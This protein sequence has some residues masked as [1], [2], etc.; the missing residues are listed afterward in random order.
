ME[1]YLKP[2]DD[3]LTMGE[4]GP[5]TSIKLDY[6]ARYIDIF[7]TAMREKW[8]DRNYIDL[9]SGA[10][11]NRIKRSN[12]ILLGSPLLAITTTY[13]FTGYLFVDNS[14]EK[15]KALEQRCSAYPFPERIKIYTGDCNKVVER[16]VDLLKPNQNHS[17]NL[18]FL[19]PQGFELEWST[20]AKLASIKRM[21]LIIYYPQMGFSRYLNEAYLTRGSNAVDKFFGGDEWR[22]IYEEV[23]RKGKKGLDRRLIDLYKSKLNILG[24]T[25]VFRGNEGVGEE[26]L[27]RNQL[28][29]TP[30]YRLLFA[31]KNQLGHEFWRK[32]IRRDVHG[33]IQLFN[34]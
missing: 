10:G 32:I 13:P 25:E 27:I 20:L 12:K 24:Y 22:K 4:Y 14:L 8:K 6:L 5:W 30:L 18:A 19:D 17:L 34:T 29:N 26:P 15:T 21:D 3:G 16:V 1:K 9:F 33:Q 2:I 7:E 28:R 11:K 31:S 23:K